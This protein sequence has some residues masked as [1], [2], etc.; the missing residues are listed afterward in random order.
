MGFS[1]S[2]S[3]FTP[4][5]SLLAFL[6]F[7]SVIPTVLLFDSCLLGLFWAYCMFSLYLIPMAWY[8]HW[9]SI[10]AVL[11]LLGPFHRFWGFLS[12]FISLGIL[13]PFH[14]LGN[15]RPIPILHSHGLLLSLLGFPNLNYHILYF[16]GLW[17]FPPTPYSLKS[18]LWASLGYRCLLSISH[19]A[20][21]FTTSFFGLLWARLPSLRPFCYF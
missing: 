19:N 9:A 17:A 1:F 15:P 21:G 3:F 20:H 2:N 8:Y 13:G 18:L 12:P 4:F 7:H 6:S 14:F 5:V 11:C 16:W 10:H